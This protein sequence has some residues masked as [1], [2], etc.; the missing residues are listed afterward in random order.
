MSSAHY[1]PSV[2]LSFTKVYLQ[3]SHSLVTPEV[4][5][6]FHLNEHLL[7]LGQRVFG[8]VVATHF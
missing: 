4:Q 8:S 3:S 1:T 6:Y 7:P 2:Y 5:D